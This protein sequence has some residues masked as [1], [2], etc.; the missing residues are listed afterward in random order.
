MRKYANAEWCTRLD[1][2]R[3]YQSLGLQGDQIRISFFPGKKGD[4]FSVAITRADARLLA[5]RINQCLDATVK[6]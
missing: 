4:G 1:F 5:K 6:K 3:P 2:D